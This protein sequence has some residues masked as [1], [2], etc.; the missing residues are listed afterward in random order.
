MMS[1]L[2][3]YINSSSKNYLEPERRGTPK[4][5]PIGTS[6]GKYIAA[7]NSLYLSDLKIISSR[8]N[9]SYALLRK[10]RTE[11]SFKSLIQMHEST[12][13]SDYL[14]PYLAQT[15]PITNLDD[16]LAENISYEIPELEEELKD[17]AEYSKGL[18]L[19]ITQTVIRQFT[20][21]GFICFSGYWQKIIYMLATWN[22][23]DLNNQLLTQYILFHKSLVLSTIG[24]N[25]SSESQINL[26]RA[27]TILLSEIAQQFSVSN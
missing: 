22:D 16:L 15:S 13:V 21:L 9:V 23:R 27:S 25:C 19:C 10:W 2:T 14:I 5:E 7:L 26:A 18:K 20:E 8:S 12:F 1:L 24:K 3:D 11:D 6:R 17:Y 4:G